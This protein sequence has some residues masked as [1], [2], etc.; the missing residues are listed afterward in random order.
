[1]PY[2]PYRGDSLQYSRDRI[3]RYWKVAGWKYAKR[4]G[5]FALFGPGAVLAAGAA[6]Y[7]TKVPRLDTMPRMIGY[8]R[9]RGQRGPMLDNSSPGTGQYAGQKISYYSKKGGRLIPKK[10]KVMNA[11]K[12]HVQTII[13]RWQQANGIGYADT[14]VPRNGARYLTAGPTVKNPPPGVSTYFWPVHLYEVTGVKNYCSAGG[15]ASTA[16]YP[17]V[18]YQLQ[19][20]WNGTAHSFSYIAMTG[21]NNGDSGDV[22]GWV[23]EVL[24]RPGSTGGD[25]PFAGTQAYID[26][27]KIKMA[28]F[29]ATELASE[30]NLSMVRFTDEQLVPPAL[31]ATN[32]TN[33]PTV[34]HDTVDQERLDAF[35]TYHLSKLVGHMNADQ[36]DYDSGKGMFKK[37]LWNFKFGPQSNDNPDPGGTQRNLT[38]DHNFNRFVKLDW[39]QGE[40]VQPGAPTASGIANVIGN[41]DYYQQYSNANSVNPSPNQTSRMFL[42]VQGDVQQY[43]DALYSTYVAG[44]NAPRCFP[45]YDLSIRRFRTLVHT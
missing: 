32:S 2:I 5:R 9:R 42:M 26:K 12:S 22:Y 35:W 20:T 33:V 21:R 34:Y 3:S 23:A 30:V 24:P 14:P 43:H 25:I 11:L 8:K 19:S 16:Y 44:A 7:F 28:V 1:M 4:L 39:F 31:S 45:S 13:E 27:L 36:I 29:G 6:N 18:A 10:K 40:D 38:L 41:P 15:V 37:S 17:S